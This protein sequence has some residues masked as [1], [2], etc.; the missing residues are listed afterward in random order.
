MISADLGGH[1]VEGRMNFGPLSPIAKPPNPPS[2]PAARTSTQVKPTE[3]GDSPAG[4]GSS[5]RVGPSDV[6]EV[7]GDGSSSC[8]MGRI[9]LRLIDGNDV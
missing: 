8:D 2:R 6:S 9:P 1:F 4:P 3:D 7:V 5:G